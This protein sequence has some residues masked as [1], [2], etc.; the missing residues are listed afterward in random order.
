MLISPDLTIAAFDD[1]LLL[2]LLST[3]TVR[4]WRVLHKRHSLYEVLTHSHRNLEA[5]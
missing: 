3:L 4:H 1:I 2:L 5:N